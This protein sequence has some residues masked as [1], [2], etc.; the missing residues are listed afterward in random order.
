[1][2]KSNNLHDMI[3]NKLGRNLEEKKINLR[4]E[5]SKILPIFLRSLKQKIETFI[6]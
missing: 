3:L 5:N 4:E 6:S 1:M 2:L